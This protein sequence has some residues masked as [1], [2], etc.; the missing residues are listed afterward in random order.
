MPLTAE[1][2]MYLCIHIHII[3]NPLKAPF[4]RRANY[5]DHNKRL[6]CHPITQT[7]HCQSQSFTTL[8]QFHAMSFVVVC[9]SSRARAKRHVEPLVDHSRVIKSEADAYTFEENDLHTNSVL[10]WISSLQK[11]NTNIFVF[12]LML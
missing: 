12:T 8:G 9:C 3:L 10:I 1:Q 6:C 7:T 2:L 11:L 4:D 5:V